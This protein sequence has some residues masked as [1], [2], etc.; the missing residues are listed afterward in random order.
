[1]VNSEDELDGDN[2]SLNDQNNND[3]NSEAL[4]R[5]FSHHN[6]QTLENEIQ[7]VTKS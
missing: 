7:R 4:I 3:E 5:V 6:D 2:Q 1:M